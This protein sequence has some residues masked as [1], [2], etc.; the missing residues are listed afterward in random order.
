MN[1]VKD[2][3]LEL[4]TDET[5]AGVLCPVLGKYRQYKTDVYIGESP[6][7]RHDEGTEVS[8]L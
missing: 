7:K 3:D 8:L 5:T 4:S 6:A 2:C 1:K